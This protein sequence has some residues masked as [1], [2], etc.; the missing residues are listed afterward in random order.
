MSSSAQE[1][2]RESAIQPSLIAVKEAVEKWARLSRDGVAVW[3]VAG[4]QLPQMWEDW[5]FCLSIHEWSQA[6]YGSSLSR[7]LTD[8]AV[9]CDDQGVAEAI[10]LAKNTI[11]LY[12]EQS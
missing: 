11:A 6:G 10:A 12:R 1:S 3:E 9:A 8:I 5:R 7:T 2:A 4:E